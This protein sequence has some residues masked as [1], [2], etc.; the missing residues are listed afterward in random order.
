MFKRALLA[1]LAAITLIFSLTSCQSPAID[2]T[3][4]GMDIDKFYA[5][6]EFTPGE[7]TIQLNESPTGYVELKNSIKYLGDKYVSG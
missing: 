4:L 2:G 3:Y 1:S 6:L 5:E 7:D